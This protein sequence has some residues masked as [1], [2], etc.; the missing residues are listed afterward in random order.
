VLIY[1][2]FLTA[3]WNI[4][5]F[6]KVSLLDFSLPPPLTLTSL[7]TQNLSIKTYS[8]QSFIDA[9]KRATVI[10]RFNNLNSNVQALV[11]RLKTFF[12]RLNLQYYYSNLIIIAV[13]KNVNLIL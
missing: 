2:D 7:T 1:R 5:G 4:K 3:R 12:F 13:A 10:N 6:L 8:L 11:T 9:S